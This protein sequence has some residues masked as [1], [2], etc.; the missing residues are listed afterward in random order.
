MSGFPRTGR[1][2]VR[3]HRLPSPPQQSE[4]VPPLPIMGSAR[5]HVRMSI[6]RHGGERV[7]TRAQGAQGHM[8]RGMSSEPACLVRRPASKVLT[9]TQPPQYGTTPQPP[10]TSHH[11]Y[12]TMVPSVKFYF[13][14]AQ[15][16]YSLGAKKK[17]IN[18][19]G[20]AIVFPVEFGLRSY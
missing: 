16:L 9:C 8:T 17:K 19:K 7:R 2:P 15:M 14:L 4:V 5:S 13:S 20:L 1:Y 10:P 18:R 3:K 11:C 6:C 12:Y